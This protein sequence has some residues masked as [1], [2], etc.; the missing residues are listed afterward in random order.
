MGR[1]LI[2]TPEEMARR[3]KIDEMLKAANVTGMAG[4]RVDYGKTSA[5]RTGKCWTA[6]RESMP[7][8]SGRMTWARL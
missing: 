4:V 6:W 8:F 1:I 7:A 5:I 2:R 3:E